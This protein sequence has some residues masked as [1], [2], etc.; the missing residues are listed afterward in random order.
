MKAGRPSTFFTAPLIHRRE[1]FGKLLKTPGIQ[2]LDQLMLKLDTALF[3]DQF[4]VP[5]HTYPSFALRGV[6]PSFASP[7]P[8]ITGVFGSEGLP[9]MG[10][11]HR[12][13]CQTNFNCMSIAAALVCISMLTATEPCAT[14]DMQEMW[15]EKTDSNYELVGTRD[16]HVNLLDRSSGETIRVF[17]MNH[18]EVVRE[19]HVLDH[20]RTLAVSQANE[21]TFWDISSGR[22]LFKAPYRI[23]A[24]SPTQTNFFIY[25]ERN[26]FW[27]SYP[28]LAEIC[29]LTSSPVMGPDSFAFS[30]DGR[31]LTIAFYSGRP[32]TDAY[33]P[34][35]E[36]QSKSYRY[37]RLFDL[38]DCREI[39]EFTRLDA[40]ILGGFSDDS[41]FLTLT[42]AAIRLDGQYMEGSWQFD[43]ETRKLATSR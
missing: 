17:T 30:P 2:F 21:T 43:L 13:S 4:S 31:F 37:A 7:E 23:Y 3:G 26:V 15:N 8:A 24:F 25:R 14:A 27:I 38:A 28:S 11:F 18:P 39:E 41:R 32:S 35:P 10:A 16:G 12:T 33:Y 1:T 19:I 40:S 5:T 22:E 42:D 34:N 36:P 9:A 6:S 20:G 29:K